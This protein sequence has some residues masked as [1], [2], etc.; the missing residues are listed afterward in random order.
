M[1]RRAY[2][3]NEAV[4]VLNLTNRMKALEPPTPVQLRWVHFFLP[5]D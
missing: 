5:R 2:L 3:A 4:I 1:N